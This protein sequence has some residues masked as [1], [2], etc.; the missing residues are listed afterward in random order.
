M[1]LDDPETGENPF[2]VL[3]TSQNL[4]S[5]DEEP[6]GGIDYRR[7]LKRCPP[8]HPKTSPSKRLGHALPKRGDK[9]FEPDGTIRQVGILQ[10]A[11]EA[12]Y[13]AL[14]SDVGLS[15]PMSAVR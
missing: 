15:L 10:E 4:S 2:P 12:M 7:L 5:D 1:A 13:S 11:R 6:S 9:D 8:P 14:N 3:Q